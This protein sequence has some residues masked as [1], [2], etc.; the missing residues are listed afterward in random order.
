MT[1]PPDAY[2]RLLDRLDAERQRS[3]KGARETSIEECALAVDGIA[4][5]LLVAATLAVRIFEGPAA[6][7]QYLREHAD[8]R[9]LTCHDGPERAA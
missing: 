6:A 7:Q 9:H 3:L 4:S 8:G 5:G 2:R 1:Y